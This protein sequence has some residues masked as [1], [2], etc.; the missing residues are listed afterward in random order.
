[1]EITIVFEQMF[2]LFFLMLVGFLLRKFKI[3]SQ[4]GNSILT[5]LILVAIIPAAI[6]T[7]VVNT[8]G[9]QG[10]LHLLY[11]LGVSIFVFILMTLLS[12][13]IARLTGAKTQEDR[14][15]LASTGLFGNIAYM[16]FPLA[17]I[18]FGSDSVFYTVLFNLVFN[19]FALSFGIKLLTGAGVK[20]SL[21][22]IFNASMNAS[23]LAIGLFMLNVSLPPLVTAPLTHLGNMLTPTGMIL[24]GS[25]LAEMNLKEILLGW[26]IY[27]AIAVK[28]L[29]AP[30]MVFFILSQF[31]SDPL[32]LGLFVVLSAV[33]A[34]PRTAMLAVHYGGNHKLVSQGIFLSTI[35]SIVTIP[36]LIFLLSL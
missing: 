6:I 35:L 14:G 16:G 32:M 1:M 23:L 8:P 31:V 3:L 15:A 7:G 25:I 21:R 18:L 27:T 19:T 11:V 13:L 29:L 33:P 34:A 28:L 4:D 26:R 10:N 9:G 17:L 36:F 5:R 24:L 22:L 30:L 12:I 2:V 20:L